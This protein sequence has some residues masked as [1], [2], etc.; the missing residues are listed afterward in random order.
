TF[1][2]GA[3]IL[4]SCVLAPV[5][6]LVALLVAVDVGPPLIFWQ[7]RP[8]REG[9]SFKLYK[10]CTMRVAHD[11]DGNRIPDEERTTKLGLWLRRTRLD[12][13]PQLFNILMGEMSFVGPRPLLPLD[14]PDDRNGRLSVAPGLTG[15]AQVYG[16]RNMPP[17][18]KNALD[19]WYIQNASL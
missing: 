10:F 15:F 13:L 2:M 16:E 14:Q 12:E 19:L 8:G 7:R 17:N 4:L 18:D 9:A 6:L 3:A 5:L 1:D 11:A